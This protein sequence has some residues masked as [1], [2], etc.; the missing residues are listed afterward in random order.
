[1]ASNPLIDQ[2]TL[3]RLRASVVIPGYPG[4]NV[5]A[6][7]LAQ[8]GISINLNGETTTI[9]QTATGTVTS[10]QPYMMATVQISMLRTQSLAALYKAQME[11]DSRVGSITVTPD[12]A[13]LPTY[14]FLNVAIESVRELQLA[15]RDP[16]YVVTLSGYYLINSNL[17]NLT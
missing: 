7:Y 5:T 6:P 1:M 17:W 13:A 11:L 3:N 9:I 8:D 2:G 10:P 12:S 14:Q 4:L 15:G 16:S